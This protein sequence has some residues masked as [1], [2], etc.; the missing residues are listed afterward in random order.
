MFSIPPNQAAYLW[1]GIQSALLCL[2]KLGFQSS[3]SAAPSQ[4]EHFSTGTRYFQP[5]GPGEG[6]HKQEGM[7]L[8]ITKQIL[9]AAQLS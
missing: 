9:E 6:N 7:E 5:Q 3:V 1:P 2:E 8:N 4:T